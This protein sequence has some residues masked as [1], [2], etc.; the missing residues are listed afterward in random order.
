VIWSI[1]I[2]ASGEDTPSTS[3]DQTL[4]EGEPSSVVEAFHYQKGFNGDPQVQNLQDQ[5]KYI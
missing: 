1:W 5:R 2:Y 4:M 3:G